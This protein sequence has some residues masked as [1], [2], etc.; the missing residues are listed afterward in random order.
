MAYNFHFPGF[1]LISVNGYPIKDWAECEAMSSDLEISSRSRHWSATRR[2]VIASIN[3]IINSCFLANDHDLVLDQ[4]KKKV[5]VKTSSFPRSFNYSLKWICQL[6]IETFLLQIRV[7]YNMHL[8]MDSTPRKSHTNHQ[9][10]C[11][12]SKCGLSPLNICAW[13]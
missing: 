5:I 11:L 10:K 3:K 12:V 1:S 13:P 6:T 7:R 9:R 8:S 2:V 4:N